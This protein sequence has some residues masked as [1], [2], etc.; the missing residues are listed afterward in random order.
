[1]KGDGG[2]SENVMGFGLW[3]GRF[4]GK[5]FDEFVVR[6]D[7]DVV[8][9]EVFQPKTEGGMKVVVFVLFVLFVWF[10]LFVVFVLFV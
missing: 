9:F 3:I 8:G 5:A 2:V 7:F 10:V 4:V 6:P 1:M